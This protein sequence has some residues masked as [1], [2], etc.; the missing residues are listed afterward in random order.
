MLNHMFKPIQYLYQIQNNT[1]ILYSDA[2]VCK[3]FLP[4]EDDD[5]FRPY[6]KLYYLS[7]YIKRM[8]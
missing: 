1:L 5:V 4:T 7:A 2:N 6:S 3:L 8:Q